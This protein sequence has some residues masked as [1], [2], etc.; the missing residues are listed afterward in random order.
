M[1]YIVARGVVTRD[2]GKY[3]SKFL[4]SISLR[5]DYILLPTR[6]ILSMLFE[7]IGT[8]G[9]KFEAEEFYLL[10][11]LSLI[12]QSHQYIII[13]RVIW[14]FVL[15]QT[16]YSSILQLFTAYRGNFRFY[17]EFNNL[18]WLDIV[19]KLKEINFPGICHKEDLVHVAKVINL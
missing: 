2:S 6:N 11:I 18:A 19:I 16:V 10:N 4:Y 14:F 17:L 1:L 8:C 9:W 7:Y 3:M 5:Y 13:S 12:F 15:I